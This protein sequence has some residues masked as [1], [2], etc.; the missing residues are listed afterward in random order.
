MIHMWDW[1]VVSFLR[2]LRQ[3]SICFLVSADFICKNQLISFDI[4]CS[5]LFSF[6][7]VVVVVFDHIIKI[8]QQM[9]FVYDLR[10]S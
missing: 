8:F 9:S 3:K 5:V 10:V 1:D 7:V 4:F 2:K 6:S